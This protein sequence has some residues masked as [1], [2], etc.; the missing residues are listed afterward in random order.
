MGNQSITFWILCHSLTLVWGWHAYIHMYVCT[1]SPHRDFVHSVPSAWVWLWLANNTLCPSH[2]S[3]AMVTGVRSWIAKRRYQQCMRQQK[4]TTSA[5][6]IQTGMKCMC[7]YSVRTY[8]QCSLY[9]SMQRL[10]SPT[11]I[12]ALQVPSAEQKRVSSSCCH[13]DRYVRTYVRTYVLMAVTEH[14]MQ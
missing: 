12:P 7:T 8:T 3:A 1:Y 6:V 11:C 13:S 5:I 10:V 9:C 14:Y 4:E 2:P